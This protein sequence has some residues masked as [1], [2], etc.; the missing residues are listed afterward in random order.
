MLSSGTYLLSWTAQLETAAASGDA[1]NFGLYDG[2]VLLATSVNPGT[3][4]SYPQAAVSAYLLGG[5]GRQSR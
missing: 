3:V 5:R 2:S 1:D 4:A